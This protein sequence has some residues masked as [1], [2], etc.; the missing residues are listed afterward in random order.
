MDSSTQQLLRYRFRTD[1]GVSNGTFPVTQNYVPT[2][3]TFTY[4]WN[5]QLDGSIQAAI[6]DSVFGSPYADTFSCPTSSCSWGMAATLALETT[7]L[8]CNYTTPG[9][10]QLNATMVSNAEVGSIPMIRTVA[11]DGQGIVSFASLIQGESGDIEH[12]QSITEC[13]L[14]YCAKVYRNAWVASGKFAAEVQNYSLTNKGIDDPTYSP[15]HDFPASLNS[16]FSVEYD[17]LSSLTRFL[18]SVLNTA[19]LDTCSGDCIDKPGDA[20]SFGIAML[21]QPS[22]AHVAENLASSL[23]NVIRNSSTMN[24]TQVIGKSYQQVQFIGVRWEWIIF[25]SS[26]I[27]LSLGILVI[28]MSQSHNSV[29]M[30]W[31]SSPLA[32]LFHPLQGWSEDEM[33]LD[34]A[35]EMEK[36][37]KKMHGQLR[38]NQ[39]GAFKIVRS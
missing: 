38:S 8:M 19:N 7:E 37:S 10:F 11:Q 39:D 32:M 23:T 4:G 21:N 26:L 12:P 6:I 1:P 34:S 30:T 9:A 3:Y 17:P 2:F 20:L 22:I 14:S 36:L 24:A 35:P 33:C 16:T 13:Q 29:S 18:V 25:P 27:L 15:G 31:R 28:T 5:G